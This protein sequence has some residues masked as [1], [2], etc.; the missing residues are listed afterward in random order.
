MGEALQTTC[1][2]QDALLAALHFQGLVD[3]TFL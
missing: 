2:M 1:S 3:Y